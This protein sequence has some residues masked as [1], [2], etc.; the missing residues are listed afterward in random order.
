M[1]LYT[2]AAAVTRHAMK[3]AKRSVTATP[4]AILDAG[5]IASKVAM[6]TP[7]TLMERSTKVSTIYYLGPPIASININSQKGQPTNSSASWR[8]SF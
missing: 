1:L 6:S 8:I 7:S 5:T 2:A 4:A 3:I